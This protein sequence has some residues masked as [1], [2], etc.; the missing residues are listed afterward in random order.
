MEHRD[1]IDF[2]KVVYVFLE[3]WGGLKAG[4]IGQGPF[5]TRHPDVEAHVQRVVWYIPV[6]FEHPDV[7][8]V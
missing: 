2:I 4:I 8:D 5:R 1:I 3:A 7:I 6:S